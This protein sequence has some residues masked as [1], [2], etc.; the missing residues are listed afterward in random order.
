L[1]VAFKILNNEFLILH[2]I[3]IEYANTPRK[4]ALKTKKIQ[5]FTLKNHNLFTRQKILHPLNEF[6]FIKPGGQPR[7]ENEFSRFSYWGNKMMIQKNNRS[8]FQRIGTSH[9][10]RRN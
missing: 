4:S 9:N 5:L 6:F 1:F 3:I 8:C 2:Q 7:P 10:N